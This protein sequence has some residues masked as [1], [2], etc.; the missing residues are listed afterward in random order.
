MESLLVYVPVIMAIACP[1]GMG[2]M[3]WMMN[4]PGGQMSG[5]KHDAPNAADRLTALQAQ[6]E[7]LNQEIAELEKIK[8]LEERRQ[9]L[10]RARTKPAETHAQ[11]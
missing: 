11:S 10:E 7:E 8:A 2:V 6:R 9:T 5:M 3:M 4:R 1:V